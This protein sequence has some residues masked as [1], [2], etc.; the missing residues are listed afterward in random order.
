MAKKTCNSSGWNNRS[1]SKKNKPKFTE[2]EK[3]AYKLGKIQA[4]LNK[5][6]RVRDSFE[7]GKKSSDKSQSK[8][9]PLY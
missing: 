9:K 1:G 3:L 5:D 7:N 6:C 2:D 4:S 8:K